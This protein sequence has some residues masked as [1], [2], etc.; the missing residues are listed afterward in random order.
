MEVKSINRYIRISPRKLRYVADIIKGKKVEEAVDIL[1]FLPQ[2][3]SAIIG[4]I[5]KSAIA[6]AGQDESIDVDTLYIKKVFVDE[7]PTLKRFRPRAMGRASK[8]KKRTSHI[9]VILDES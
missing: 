5:V 7:G 4:K 8:I 9:T 3:A 6:N 2:K 1:T